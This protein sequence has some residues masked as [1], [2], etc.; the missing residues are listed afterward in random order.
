[1]P[2]HAQHTHWTLESRSTAYSLALHPTGMLVH[3]YWGPKLPD[4]EDYFQEQ[5]DDRIVVGSYVLQEVP[6][7]GLGN[8]LREEYPAY[9]GAKYI[10]PCLKASFADGVRDVVLVFERAEI[11]D[12]NIPEL[13]I[14]MCDIH[15]PLSLV[16]HYRV[17]EEFDLIERFATI[18]N[19]G[20]TPVTLERIWSAQWHLPVG[21]HYHMSHLHGHWA[22]EFQLSREPLTSGVKVLESRRITTSHHHS[23]WFAIDQGTIGEEHGNLWFGVLAWSGNW[24]IAAEV[25]DFA[26][27]RIS[28]GVNDWDFAWR[29][30]GG[31]TFT[32]P[33]S[34]GGFTI[35]GYGAASR[36]LHD[37]IRSTIVPHGIAPRKVLFNSWETTMFEVDEESQKHFA[38]I[39]AEMGVELYVMDDGWFHGRASDRAG[40][41]DWWPDE[42]KFPN[43]LTP[44]IEHVNQL[45]MEFGLW[46]EPEMV[47]PDSDLYREHPDWVIHFP[48]RQRTE[49]RHQL[50]LNM[51]KPEVQDYLIDHLDR[52]LATHNIRF[53][54]WDMNR[55]VS[56]PGWPDAPAYQRELWVRYV[57]GLYRVW[58]TLRERHPDVVWQ[59]C[60]G[61]GGRADLGILRRAD[62]IW[63]SDNTIPTSRLAIQDGYSQVFPAITMESWVT[64]MGDDFLPLT[65]R[66]H[67]S[68]CGALGVGADLRRWG[69]TELAEAKHCISLYKELRPIIQQG[70]MY[71]LKNHSIP[72]LS[73]VQ[74]I[75]KDKTAGVLFAFLTHR[76]DFAQPL[77]L[78]PHGLDPDA[79]YRVDGIR[80]EQSGIA[81]MRTGITLTLDDYQSV[82]L[83]IGK[84]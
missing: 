61:G 52:L 84:Q 7:N 38:D 83:R 78:Y 28:V 3:H 68:M 32:T 10:E 62:Q 57:Y 82:A 76:S 13:R 19:T 18:G 37:F 20:D 54:K 39:A 60:S 46:I 53:I 34:I 11:I 35:H 65:F 44:L 48:T 72:A 69:K 6:F 75:R 24:K 25:T 45:G 36:K 70:D 42:Q 1:M 58:D 17:W 55:N 12:G 27:T 74:Y 22:N 50:I 30:E 79:K 21:G 64:D 51:A 31:S 15:Y 63:V 47:N 33:P 14:H 56:E 4:P 71:R 59:S 43:G 8:V 81:W 9:A 73:G 67:V 77:V 40:L 16:L 49:S 2:I 26:T 5:A 29:L 66:F 41:G 80:G 23:P